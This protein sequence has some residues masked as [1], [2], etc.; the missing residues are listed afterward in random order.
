MDTT[1]NLVGG[2][3][4]SSEK[5]NKNTYIGF[6][7][8]KKGGMKIIQGDKD[9]KIISI[10][11]KILGHLNKVFLGGKR[12]KEK[13]IK[14]YFKAL[15]GKYIRNDMCISGNNP[16]CNS[17]KNV[18]IEGAHKLLKLINKKNIPMDSALEIFK[19]S[20]PQLYEK[21]ETK[22]KGGYKGIANDSDSNSSRGG[23]PDD[24]KPAQCDVGGITVKLDD[25]RYAGDFRDLDGFQ[26]GVIFD[27][28]YFNDNPKF[29]ANVLDLLNKTTGLMNSQFATSGG[30]NGRTWADFKAFLSAIE[31]ELINK[32]V[33]SEATYNA[34]NKQTGLIKQITSTPTLDLAGCVKGV[35]AIEDKN[36]FLH[37]LGVWGHNN[38]KRYL[39]NKSAARDYDANYKYKSSKWHGGYNNNYQGEGGDLFSMGL[40]FAKKFA[41]DNFDKIKQDAT[42]FTK[43]KINELKE[44]AEKHVNNLVSEHL[45]NL[46]KGG[47]DDRYDD[48]YDNRYDNRGGYDN[49]YDDMYGGYKIEYNNLRE[50]I[51]NIKI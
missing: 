29:R 2:G 32:Q 45:N 33:I 42:K 26:C 47:Y 24:C 23:G 34:I 3:D 27:V 25:S 38:L 37:L 20:A 1:N 15:G 31:S 46:N 51:L 4:S 39:L 36:E 41:T 9:E 22:I 5:Y 17:G 48:R 49:M 19:G 10:R 44:D 16:S 11:N 12:L 35:N 7:K 21:L 43:D 50:Q 14:K 40:D 8:M 13:N 18:S 30:K 28:G 6:L